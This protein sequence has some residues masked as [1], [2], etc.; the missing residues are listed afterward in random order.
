MTQARIPRAVP[1]DSPEGYCSDIYIEHYQPRSLTKLVLLNAMVLPKKPMVMVSEPTTLENV[2]SLVRISERIESYIGHESTARLLSQLLSVDIAVN[3]G[4]YEPK[5]GDVAIV[6]K[7][8]KRLQTPQDVRDVKLED[9]EFYIVV[10]EEDQ[11]RD[12][13]PVFVIYTLPG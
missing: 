11:V 1:W 3:R 10:Y 9:I 4:E 8:K 2:K 5:V 13:P 7:L 6:V 12:E